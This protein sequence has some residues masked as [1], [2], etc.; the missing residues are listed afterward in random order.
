MTKHAL[1]DHPVLT[2]QEFAQVPLRCA[3]GGC[4]NTQKGGLPTHWVFLIVYNSAQPEYER[5]LSDITMDPY[6]LDTVL[7]GTHAKELEM[8]LKPWAECQLDYSAIK[9]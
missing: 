5:T 3:W 2:L 9:A 4:T 1:K 6:T 8:L 7:C